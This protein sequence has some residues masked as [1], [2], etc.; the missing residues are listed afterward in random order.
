MGLFKRL[1]GLFAAPPAR[2]GQG[3]FYV[4]A[5]R[6]NRCGEVVEGRINL[7][8]DLSWEDNASGEG[9][10]STLVCRKVLIGT[11]RC[12][13]PLEVVLR[14]DANRRLLDKQVTGGRFEA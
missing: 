9:A 2:G 12:F 5:V 14:F 6:C 7:N 8:N 3:N 4:V 11:Q 10:A 1:A 13:Q